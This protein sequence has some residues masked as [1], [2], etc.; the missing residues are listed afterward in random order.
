LPQTLSVGEDLL[1]KMAKLQ[2]VEDS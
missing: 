1:R 2:E